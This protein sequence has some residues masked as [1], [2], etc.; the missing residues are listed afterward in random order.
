MLSD[1][2][3]QFWNSRHQGGFRTGLTGNHTS[4][5]QKRKKDVA[6][7]LTGV[8]VLWAASMGS[9]PELWA[10][11]QTAL[12]E[13]VGKLEPTVAYDMGVKPSVLRG[14]SFHRAGVRSS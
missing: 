4:Q 7:L 13:R 10:G 11:P 12:W 6:A 2:G 1:L 3:S 5:G 14:S 8:Q 9:D